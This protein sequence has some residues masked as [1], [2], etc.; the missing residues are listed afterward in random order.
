MGSHATCGHHAAVQ[1]D[2]AM[3]D[4]ASIRARAPSRSFRQ[5]SQRP[6][7]VTASAAALTRM[8]RRLAA[9]HADQPEVV[10]VCEKWRQRVATLECQ[11]QALEAD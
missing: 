2:N 6:D 4:S 7:G 10:A 11:A 3:T 8:I 9:R 5:L 1:Q